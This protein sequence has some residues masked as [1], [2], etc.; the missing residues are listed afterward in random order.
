M[1]PRIPRHLSSPVAMRPGSVYHVTTRAVA[2]TALFETPRDYLTF[3]SQLAEQCRVRELLVHAFCCMTTH[4]HLQLEDRR[5][6][7]SQAMSIVKSLYARYYNGTRE[8]GRRHGALWAER[9]NAEV[10]DSKRYFDASAAYV[11]LNPMRTKKPMVESPERYPWS[12]CAMTVVDGV[13]PADY[14]RHHVE[15]AGGVDAILDSMPKPATKASGENRRRRFDILL[16]G[17][18]FVTEAVLGHRTRDEYLAHLLAKVGVEKAELHEAS[19]AAGYETDEEVRHRPA[20]TL[21]SPQ[22]VSSV[23]SVDANGIP[24]LLESFKGLARKAAVDRI[25]SSVREWLPVGGKNRRELRDAEIWVLWRFTSHSVRKIAKIARV[26][27]D[28]V[29][30]ALRRVR[31]LRLKERA[32]WR[33]IWSAEWSLR[34]SLCAA[35]WRE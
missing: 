24:R 9:F 21:G 14:F 34:W 20:Q 8:G 1:M 17:K 3:L 5:G 7:I 12:S 23:S 31:A 26:T 15:K 32:W 6:Q 19:E 25:V 10:I 18:E 28:E 16:S 29:D 30:R 35:P 2:N 4:V 22:S 33:A 27:A 13:T 11:Q